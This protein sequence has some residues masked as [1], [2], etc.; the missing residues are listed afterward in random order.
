MRLRPT[1]G[2]ALL[3][4]V[5][6]GVAVYAFDSFIE[7]RDWSARVERPV[8]FFAMVLLLVVPG[9]LFAI[10]PLPKPR[11]GIPGIP[12]NQP[13]RKVWPKKMLRGFLFLAAVVATTRILEAASFSF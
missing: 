11:E 9:C 8:T 7:P 12:L 10:G 5:L 1:V 3:A 13:P 6:S 2:S 4:G